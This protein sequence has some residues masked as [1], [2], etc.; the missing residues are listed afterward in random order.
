MASHLVVTPPLT[1]Q[2]WNPEKKQI[3]NEVNKRKQV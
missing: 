3:S 2:K 1:N